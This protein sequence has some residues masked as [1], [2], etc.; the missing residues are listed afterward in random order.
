MNKTIKESIKE[1]MLLSTAGLLTG[2][3]TAIWFLIH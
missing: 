1:F 2:L 3:C